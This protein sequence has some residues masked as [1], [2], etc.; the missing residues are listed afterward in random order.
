VRWR[1]AIALLATSCS[2]RHPLVVNGEAALYEIP[3]VELESA[4]GFYER[5]LETRLE[6]ATID[7]LDMA[8]FPEA[9]GGASGALVKGETYVPSRD[10]TRV[11][12]RVASVRET[13][14]RAVSAGGRVLYEARAVTPTAIVGEFEDLEG[15]RVA[16]IER[17]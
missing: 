8:L 7:G 15:N 11:Y 1:V 2:V 12:L 9:V 6:R 13:L 10:G 17:R 5:V 14:A 16:L 3:V 4:I